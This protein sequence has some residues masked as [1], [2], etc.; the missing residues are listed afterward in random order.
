LLAPQP[1]LAFSL[2]KKKKKKKPTPSRADAFKPTHSGP[3]PGQQQS[4]IN[5]DQSQVNNNNPS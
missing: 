1:A 5:I 3:F 2:I 4:H